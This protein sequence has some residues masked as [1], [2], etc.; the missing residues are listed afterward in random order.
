[1]NAYEAWTLAIAALSL[2]L[3]STTFYHWFLDR[4]VRLRVVCR[5]S[6]LFDPERGVRL[7]WGFTV[8]VVNLSAF[9]VWITEVGYLD[10]KGPGRFTIMMAD[11]NSKFL[12]LPLKLDARQSLRGFVRP[13]DLLTA[14]RE[15][16]GRMFVQTECG[17]VVK[18]PRYADAIR[19]G[20]T[21]GAI[22]AGAASG[23]LTQRQIDACLSKRPRQRAS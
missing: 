7:G 19:L 22:D 6:N 1:M 11:A 13:N 20:L 10:P 21:L 16:P 2:A 3:S 9:P 8:V 23:L 14:G 18:G 15:R 4:R 17:R 5:P 12:A